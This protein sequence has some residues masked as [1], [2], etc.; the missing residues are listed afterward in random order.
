MSMYFVPCWIVSHD[1]YG[2]PYWTLMTLH[3]PVNPPKPL[4]PKSEDSKDSKDSKDSMF[5]IR[6]GKW[7]EVYDKVDGTKTWY[8][9]LTKKTT[10]KDPFM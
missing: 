4:E 1:S 2:I 8:N 3:A 9:T 10:M 6:I 5:R 7:E